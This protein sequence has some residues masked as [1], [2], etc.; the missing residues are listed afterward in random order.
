M[1]RARRTCSWKSEHNCPAL[2]TGPDNL[3]DEHRVERER[4]RGSSTA[5][6]YD[7]EHFRTRA[8][9]IRELFRL[10]PQERICDLCGEEMLRSDRLHLDHT[11]RL[12]EDRSARGDRIVHG[13]CNEKRKKALQ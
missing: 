10:P 5:R 2:A 7:A 13:T 3:C 8:R 12:V 4:R 6:G 9:L 11:I 1:P